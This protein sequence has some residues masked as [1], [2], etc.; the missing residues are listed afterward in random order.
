[1]NG[2]V[3]LSAF[4]VDDTDHNAASGEYELQKECSKHCDDVINKEHIQG[5]PAARKDREGSGRIITCQSHYNRKLD[6]CFILKSF[7]YTADTHLIR[8]IFE[9]NEHK[10]YGMCVEH[11][12]DVSLDCSSQNWLDIKINTMEK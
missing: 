2:Y 5:P 1:M 9:T 12:Y 6:K 3:P 4:P 10:L 8:Q 11:S 7:V